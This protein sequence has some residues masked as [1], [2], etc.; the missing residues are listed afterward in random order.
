VPGAERHRRPR[1]GREARCLTGRRLRGRI[2]HG[3]RRLGEHDARWEAHVAATKSWEANRQHAYAAAA[4]EAREK[5]QRRGK[6][7]GAVSFEAQEAGWEAARSFEESTPP[8]S[9]NGV[10]STSLIYTDDPKPGL[11]DR[12]KAGVSS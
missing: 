8:P 9:F 2:R 11:L 7:E 1:L 3:T 12:V 6:G 10:T 5:A 4:A